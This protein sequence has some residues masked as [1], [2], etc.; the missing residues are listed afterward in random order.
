MNTFFI[1][2]MLD[3]EMQHFFSMYK[4]L[5]G[6]FHIELMSIHVILYCSDLFRGRRKTR[7]PVSNLQSSTTSGAGIFVK[8]YRLIKF[9]YI[10]IIGK[11]YRNNSLR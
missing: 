10:E 1:Q 8:G 2:E 9:F 7:S 5:C 4:N 6:Y 11:Y 3:F